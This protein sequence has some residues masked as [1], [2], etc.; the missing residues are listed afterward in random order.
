MKKWL[1]IVLN[2]LKT[3]KKPS[4]F[5]INDKHI[6]LTGV[7]AGFVMFGVGLGMIWLPLSL[8]VCGAFMMWCFWPGR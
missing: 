4:K 2:W 7:I 3:R 5:K 8:M 1:E 6:S